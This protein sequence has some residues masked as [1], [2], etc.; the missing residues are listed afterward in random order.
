MLR[1][2]LT[3]VLAI[4]LMVSA[5]A[6][7][8]DRQDDVVVTARKPIDAQEARHFVHE[9]SAATDGQ[10]AR[11]D[12]EV[13][14]LVIGFT[15]E[16]EKLIVARIRRVAKA[17]GAEM[18]KPDCRGNVVLVATDDGAALVQELRASRP[19]LF[20]GMQPVEIRRVVADKGPVR[21]WTATAVV[22]EDGRR[23]APPRSGK[24]RELSTLEVKT[25]SFINPSS[26]QIIDASTVV[27]DSGAIAGK[28]VI[29]LADY[30]AMRAL[31]R[32][33]PVED[34]G[35]IGTIL[36]LFDSA[37]PPQSVTDTDVAYLK[38]LYAMP[39]NRALNYQVGRIAKGIKAASAPKP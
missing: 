28:T 15:A 10:I 21:S 37:T 19:D 9:I 13:C 34:T 3:G 4:G 11:F 38:A 39:G 5:N 30:A 14:P 26:K 7:A 35:G 25:A 31:A 33:R 18:A 6:T 8:Q 20:A 36:T 27:I 2:G 22:S 17:V 1:A 12:A 29:Q 32:T 23:V 24:I 16:F